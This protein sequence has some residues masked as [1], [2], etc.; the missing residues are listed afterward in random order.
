M[1]R[2]VLTSWNSF[3]LVFVKLSDSK[4]FTIWVL[5]IIRRVIKCQKWFLRFII[6]HKHLV[7]HKL[8]F[9]A[10]ISLLKR[11]CRSPFYSY[12]KQLFGWIGHEIS[13]AVD[14]SQIE[15]GFCPV[16]ATY[17]LIS[18]LPPFRIN[19]VLPQKFHT[20]HHGL[21]NDLSA[22]MPVSPAL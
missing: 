21:T 10:H 9:A 14:Q 15:A 20:W 13:I 6:L 7:R 5:S 17:L 22:K 11:F 3:P 19:V 16:N 4:Y 8:R 1:V 12:P 18:G 2:G